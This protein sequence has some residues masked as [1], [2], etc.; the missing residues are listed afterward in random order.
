MKIQ[1]LSKVCAAVVCA[2]TFSASAANVAVADMAKVQSD[3]INAVLGLKGAVTAKAVKTVDIAQTGLTVAKFQQQLHG[4]DVFGA[5]FNGYLSP[6]GVISGVNGQF[7]QG[8]ASHRDLRISRI[9]KAQAIDLAIAADRDGLSLADVRNVSAQEYIYP[10]NGKFVRGYIV[11]YF[12]DASGS[13]KRIEN[14]I[15][16]KNGDILNRRDILANA[17]ATGPGGNTKTGR[18]NYGTDFGALDVAYSGGTSTMNSTNV[19]TIDMNNGTSATAAYSF[20]GTNNTYRSINGA[21]SPLNDAHYFGNVI[22]NM[23]N[24]YINTPPLSFQL[25]MRVHYRSN[26]ENAIWDGSAMSFGDGATTFYPLV[27]LDVSSHEVSHGFTEQNSGLVYANMSGGMNEAFSD[28]AGEAAEFFMNGTNDWMVGEQIFKGNGALRY[29]QDP[30]QDGSSIGHA[31]D[32]ISSMDVHHSSGVYNRAFYLLATTAGWDTKE[33]FQV[34]SKANQLY[35][36]AN[37]TFNAGADGVCKAA[38]DLGYSKADV[39]AAFATVGVNTTQCGGTTPPTS[40]GLTKGVAVSVAGASGSQTKFTYV[41]ASNADVVTITL[42]GGSGD[43]DLHVKKGAAVST[44]NYDCRP[45][46]GGN[47]ETCTLSGPGTYNILLN[48]Y[49]AYSSASLVADNTETAPPSNGASG[50]IDDISV[51][52]GAWQRW[53][54][55]VPAGA[56]DLTYTI[57]GGSGDA[58]LY[59]RFGSQPTTS[60]YDCRPYKNGNAETCVD[61]NPSA[62]ISHIGVYGYAAVAGLTLDWSYE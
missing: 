60:S 46:V 50:T 6:M 37:S 7:E 52:R 30:T 5:T 1:N 43:A 45:Y 8:L 39:G 26:Y 17:T 31:S 28:M 35:W 15:S 3:N 59:T 49:S 47:N 29:M 13:P 19:K 24:D 4:I 23:Y 40:G 53:T 2:L 12:S 27:S 20:S 51:A 61:A 34:M 33:A 54:L 36:T 38:D 58:D 55:T 44:S 10:L 18:Y 25:T 32:Y 21:Y 57:G 9:S 14:L 11:T 62:G 56:S 22:F 41:A 48:G 42:S 16:S